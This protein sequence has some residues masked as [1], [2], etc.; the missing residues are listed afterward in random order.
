MLYKAAATGTFHVDQ[1]DWHGGIAG[2][3]CMICWALLASGHITRLK[4][5]GWQSLR[6]T[7]MRVTS[8]SDTIGT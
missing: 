5:A 8:P 6:L 7:P 4:V 3:A 1:A 2:L